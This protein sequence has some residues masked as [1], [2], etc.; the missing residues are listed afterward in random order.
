MT[1]RG[2]RTWH[3]RAPSRH[4]YWLPAT[5]VACPHRPELRISASA[6][7]TANDFLHRVLTPVISQT[8]GPDYRGLQVHTPY[9]LRTLRSK[10]AI[11]HGWISEEAELGLAPLT[12]DLIDRRAMAFLKMTS[13]HIYR[14][15]D[16]GRSD[17]VALTG[18]PLIHRITRRNSTE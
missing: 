13:F 4:S 9:I 8:P 15:R 11:G 14:H 12:G 1:A 2:L 18:D 10:P 7:P 17:A 16:S 6:R 3:S 5:P